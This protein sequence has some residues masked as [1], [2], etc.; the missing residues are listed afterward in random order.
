M[1]Y[2]LAIVANAA[3][4][5]DKVA[6]LSTLVSEVAGQF[7]GEILVQDDWGVKTLAQATSNGLT[8]GH[9]IFFI[10]KANSEANKEITRRLSIDE[11]VIKNLFIK[12][13]EEEEV[14]K[15][16]KA[17]KTPF[18]KKYKGSAT[19][20]IEEKFGEME[21]DRKKFARRKSCWFS[22]KSIKADWK[23]PAT[24]SWLVNEFGKISPSRVSGISRKHQ[25]FVTTA[26]KRARQV[27]IVSHMSNRIA[28]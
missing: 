16:V 2:E 6:A 17:Y 12:L 15:I 24:Y 28:E 1:I 4:G 10:Y 23:D 22:A 21:K 7:D 20:A 25:R 14:D 5:D 3:C 26:I 9:F 13:G 18:S 27:G 11:Q 8:K 19:D